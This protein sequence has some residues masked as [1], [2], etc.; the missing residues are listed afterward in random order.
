MPVPE[1]GTVCGLFEALSVIVMLPVRDPSW[2]GVKVTLTTQFFPAARVLPQGFELVTC[3]KSPLVVML[4]MISDAFPVLLTVTVFPVE[5]VP[6]TVLPNTSDVGDRVTTG[7]P[8]CVTVRLIV[9]V[10]V[11]LPDVPVIVTVE[12]PVAAVALAVSV[13]R[14]VVVV[15]SG[16]NAAVTPLGR[17]EAVRLTLPVKPLAGTTVMV[18]V[19]LPPCAMLRL[20]GFAVRL[21]SAPATTVTGTPFES[22]PLATAYK[23]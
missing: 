12:V 17:P 19:P 6:T 14:L 21:K 15:G 4:A 23:V 11:K 7:P 3:A 13:N 9:V 16:T 22:M 18:L 8:P 10:A 1:S 5:V 20:L 2:V